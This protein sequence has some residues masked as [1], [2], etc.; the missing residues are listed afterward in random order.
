[1]KKRDRRLTPT[2]ISLVAGWD[3]AVSREIT[4]VKPDT[5]SAFYLDG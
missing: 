1:M 3:E 5:A 4:E 2:N